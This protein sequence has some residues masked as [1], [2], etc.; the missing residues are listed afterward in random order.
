MSLKRCSARTLPVMPRACALARTRGGESDQLLQGE[1][2]GGAVL[3]LR[4]RRRHRQPLALALQRPPAGG[5]HQL[6]RLRGRCG[7]SARGRQARGDARSAR[8]H[9]A[10]P[11]EMVVCAVDS[12]SSVALRCA[13]AQAATSGW[14]WGLKEGEARATPTACLRRQA[15]CARVAPHAPCSLVSTALRGGPSWRRAR[16][17]PEGARGGVRDAAPRV[18]S[19]RLLRARRDAL[20]EQARQFA[21]RE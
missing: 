21:A 9:A 6:Q 14:T 5:E 18:R 17:R 19:A 20:P 11:R 7:A 3:R 1:R 13:S 4:R 15:R 16:R 2:A 8:A 12:S 10:S